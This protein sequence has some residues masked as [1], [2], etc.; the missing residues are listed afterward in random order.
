MNTTL[1]IIIGAA[2]LFML[3]LLLKDNTDENDSSYNR[4]EKVDWKRSRRGGKSSSGGA[5]KPKTKVSNTPAPKR[6]PSPKQSSPITKAASPINEAQSWKKATSWKSGTSPE[7]KGFNL[8][9]EDDIVLPH[10]AVQSLYQSIVPPPA[11]SSPEDDPYA[12]EGPSFEEI[13]ADPTPLSFLDN[14]EY[15]HFLP[16]ETMES[17]ISDL[18][19]NCSADEIGRITGYIAPDYAQSF[20]RTNFA[21]YRFDDKLLGHIPV[22]DLEELKELNPDNK[23]CPFVGEISLNS[24]GWLVADIKIIMPQS[25]DFVKDEIFSYE[26]DVVNR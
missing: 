3:F 9:K 22:T 6:N 15:D 13:T 17:S 11:P 1:Y 26:P 7:V 5:S 12:E 16:C 2:V 8:K 24:K 21:V 14:L 23:E 18:R 20:G 19:F 25:L 10:P 4:D